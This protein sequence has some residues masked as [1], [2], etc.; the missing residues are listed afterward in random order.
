MGEKVK[1]EVKEEVEIKQEIKEDTEV[2]KDTKKKSTTKSKTQTKSKSTKKDNSKDKINKAVKS[3]KSVAP[4][5]RKKR[6]M[7]EM[8][9]VI[10][11][12]NSPLVY[13]SKNQIGYRIEWDEYLQENWMEY[14]ELINMRNSQRSFFSAPWIICDWDVLEDL[15]VTQ[16]Y[17][18]M[19]DLENLDDVFEKSP[20]ELAHIL[21]IAPRGIKQLISGRA[22]ELIRNKQLDSISI[23]ETIENTLN[24]DLSI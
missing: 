15:K 21:E 6:D 10:S 4:E 16:Y 22:Y 19:I 12:V 20:E 14:K 5:V 3:V 11:I 17:K 9:E 18:N 13:V 7:N 23:I 1:K 2:K 8:I 24:V